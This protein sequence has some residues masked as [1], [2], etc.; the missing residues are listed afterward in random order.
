MCTSFGKSFSL[1]TT[2]WLSTVYRCLTAILK[3]D[4]PRV[5]TN[6][7]TTRLSVLTDIPK[8]NTFSS[9]CFCM[10]STELVFQKKRLANKIASNV[11]YVFATE[12]MRWHG[13]YFLIG[14]GH[15]LIHWDQKLIFWG[16]KLYHGHEAYNLNPWLNM[17]W[18]CHASVI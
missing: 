8:T 17:L 9:K 16:H 14:H 3:N 7:S 10:Y 5:K 11:Q 13:G 2:I 15:K 12:P 4:R 1:W 6:M 18:E